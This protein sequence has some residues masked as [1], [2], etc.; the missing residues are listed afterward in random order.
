[1]TMAK[2]M[3]RR[4]FTRRASAAGAFSLG[5][6]H[7]L[8]AA[9]ANSQLQP[10]REFGYRQVA[11]RS[12]AHEAQ[13]QETLEVLMNLSEDS[14]LK[15]FREMAGL[16]APGEDLG[17]WYSYV[18]DY[19]LSHDTGLAPGSTFG[20]WVSALAR[21]YA[22]TGSSELREKVLRLNRLYAATISEA[23]FEKNRFPAYCY[24]KLLVGLIDSHQYV[25]DPDAFA[26]LARTTAAALPELP[27]RAIDREVP[28]RRTMDQSFRWD[29]SYTI[30]ENLFLASERGAGRLYAKLA[31]DYLDEASWFDALAE[32]KNVLHHKHAYSYV[33]SLSSAMQAYLALGS[34]KH[35]RAAINAFAMLQA[36]SFATGGW[37]PDEMLQGPDDDALYAG[38]EKNHNSFETPCGAYAHFK[39]TR[40]LLRATHDARY[41]DSMERLMYN[42]VLGALPMHED[43][44][45]FYY[46]DY[47]DGGSKQYS[48][49][50]FP[51]C[52][53]TLPQVAADYRIN[54]YF[55]G[56]HAIY[57]NL[58]LPS[59]LV[60][61]QDG[62]RLSLS[63]QGDYPFSDFVSLKLATS[64]SVRLALKLRIPAWADQS[65][66]AVNGRAIAISPVPGTFA[67]I[68]REWRNGDRIDLELPRRLRLEAIAPRHPD[69]VALLSGPLVLFQLGRAGTPR[70]IITRRLLMSARQMSVARWTAEDADQSLTF[71]PFV[72]I[73]D[74]TYSTYMRVG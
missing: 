58:Y 4:E 48:N 42:T 46:S 2:L 62:V 23:Y 8:A 49:H 60:W 26:I 18:S 35:L 20:Q 74:E 12:A 59:T 29:E 71:A 44:R 65:R 34:R 32:G 68:V 57:V 22:I 9:A 16:E 21:N 63:Q 31:S 40:Y 5:A 69:I 11:M 1:M 7:V 43:G 10:L 55:H 14:L 27:G 50:R 39:L 72:G 54:T 13:R 3:T 67:S 19:D 30:P 28:W 64:A 61:Q 70:P 33:N 36:Q 6:P 41:G 38:I 37:G 66:I 17:G 56:P 24:D 45:A 52:S 25:A 73:T 53:G 51:C 47:H 15:P